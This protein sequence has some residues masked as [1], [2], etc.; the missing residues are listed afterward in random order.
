M[1]GLTIDEDGKLAWIEPTG[2]PN[3][4]DGTVDA[5]EFALCPEVDIPLTAPK[6]PTALDPKQNSLHVGL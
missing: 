1:T 5:N 2:S 3:P 4:N 6:D